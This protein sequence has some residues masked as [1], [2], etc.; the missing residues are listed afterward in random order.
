[1]ESLYV[2]FQF[3][4]QSEDDKVDYSSLF[5]K[6]F[7]YSKENQREIKDFIKNYF[8]LEKEEHKE[9]LWEKLTKDL[10]LNYNCAKNIIKHIEDNFFADC[11]YISKIEYDEWEET[12]KT[13]QALW[14]L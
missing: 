9:K 12:G 13:V 2:L 3:E 11:E 10:N 7:K 6:E 14:Y 4:F 5:A 8:S 1:M